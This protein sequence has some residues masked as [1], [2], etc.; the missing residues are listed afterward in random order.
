MNLNLVKVLPSLVLVALVATPA[1][2]QSR[3]YA[4]GT[5]A[6]E[7]GHTAD[8]GGGG[9][10]LGTFPAAGGL[11]GWRFSDAWSMELHIDHGFG[12]GTRERIGHF[13]T[14]TLEDRAGEGFSVF[15]IWRS[16]PIGRLRV[17]ASMGISERRFETERTVGIDEPVNLPADDPLLRGDTRKERA[18][19]LTGG[20]LLPISLGG[21]WSV[22]PELRVGPTFMGEG[23]YLRVYSGVRMMWGF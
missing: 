12:D 21:C 16:R 7:S 23:I 19:G 13:G 3:F 6:G 15:G 5:V 10:A 1:A 14:D 8:S 22:A 18:V 4:G 2:A 17:A 9:L 11:V 20:V